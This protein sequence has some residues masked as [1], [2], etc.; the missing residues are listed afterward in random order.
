M[1]I[2]FTIFLPVITRHGD[3]VEVPQIA[4]ISAKKAIIMLEN[5]GLKP[6]IVDSQYVP[7]LPPLTVI[8]Q[9]PYPGSKVKPGRSVYLVVNKVIPPLVSLPKILNMDVNQAVSILKSWG[10]KPGHISYTEDFA[11]NTVLNV[12]FQGKEIKPG[13]KV[14]LG[15]KIDLLVSKGLGNMKVAIPDLVGMEGG[16][17]ISFVLTSGLKLGTISY[18]PGSKLPEGS[19]YAQHP[20]FV[21]GDSIS[22]G[23]TVD[24]FI[25]GKE[26]EEAIEGESNE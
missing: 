13:S 5:E 20:K 24:I 15:S 22:Y 3:F 26:P 17:A 16:E 12:R 25:S 7:D 23:V 19:V 9:D 6:V 11:L 21:V 8:T 4:Q 2:L 14:R 10:L 1:V 18:N